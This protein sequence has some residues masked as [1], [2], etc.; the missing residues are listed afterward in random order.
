MYFIISQDILLTLKAKIYPLLPRQNGSHTT[1]QH[2]T[3]MTADMLRYS[4]M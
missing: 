4:W 3:A 1:M 2:Q